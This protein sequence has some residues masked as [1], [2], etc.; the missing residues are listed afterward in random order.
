MKMDGLPSHI[1]KSYRSQNIKASELRLLFAHTIV[2]RSAYTKSRT[3]TTK[4]KQTKQ[5]P[6]QTTN[7]S[8]VEYTVSELHYSKQECHY[9]RAYFTRLFLEI[10]VNRNVRMNIYSEGLP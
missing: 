4:T 9:C 5:P 3:K 7:M 8:T 10:E 2:L 6:P 1:R